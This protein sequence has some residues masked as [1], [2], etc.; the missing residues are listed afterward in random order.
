MSTTSSEYT[1]CFRKLL[2]VRLAEFKKNW[3]LFHQRQGSSWM[4]IDC[5][6]GKDKRESLEKLHNIR[7]ASKNQDVQTT[8]LKQKEQNTAD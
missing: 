1:F 7:D 6:Y 3:F 4:K 5:V 8:I 2:R